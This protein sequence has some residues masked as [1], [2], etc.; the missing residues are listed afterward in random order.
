MI[1]SREGF[2]APDLAALQYT[3]RIDFENPLEPVF[4]YPCSSVRLRFRGTAIGVRITNRHSFYENSV[5]VILDG[6]QKKLILSDCAECREYVI[7]DDLSDGEHEVLL[8]KRMDSCHHFV[9]HGFTL[10]PGA[11]LLPPGERPARRME[12]YG[13]SVTAGEVSEAVEYCGK[14]DPE[15]NGVYSNSWY[16]YAWLTARRLGAELHDVAQGGIALLKGTG[17][18]CAPELWGMEY[19]YD[20]IQNNPYI[21]PPKQWDFAKY[22]PHVVVIAIGQNDNHPVDI[23]A[24]DIENPEAKNWRTHYAA[25]VSRIRSLYPGATI[26]LATTILNHG[27][28]WDLAIGEAAKALQDPKIHH[29]LYSNNGCGTPGHIRIPEAQRMAEELSAFIESLGDSIWEDVT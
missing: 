25:F 14:P 1:Q 24:S 20:K 3:G 17:Y 26:I 19:L 16:S 8:F 27:K 10:S 22:T 13:D 6:Q 9:F 7:E 11:A 28:N 2:A 18:Y 15:H 21:E 29:F 4:V 23:M 12:F 5:G